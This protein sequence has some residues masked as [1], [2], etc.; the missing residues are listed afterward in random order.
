MQSLELKPQRQR[1][2]IPR[3]A[4]VG[5]P[6]MGGPL[7]PTRV[8][9][10]VRPKQPKFIDAR[11]VDPNRY[12]PEQIAKMQEEARMRFEA[13][14]EKLRREGP[15][16]PT[17]SKIKVAKGIN[18]ADA[19]PEEIAMLDKLRREQLKNMGG[20]RPQPIQFT[21]P[22]NRPMIPPTANRPL[23]PKPQRPRRVMPRRGMQSLELKPQRRRVR[24]RVR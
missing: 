22:P 14:M 3:R 21:T 7:P 9:R 17:G 20:T 1:V 12:T 5:P 4:P 18:I 19:S 8:R 16:P 15:P 11:G 13:Y 6:K 24:R 23:K 2:R 10:R